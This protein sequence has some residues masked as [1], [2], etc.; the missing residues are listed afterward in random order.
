MPP[1]GSG[2]RIGRRVGVV[3]LVV[4]ASTSLIATTPVRVPALTSARSTISRSLPIAWAGAPGN[5]RAARSI[6]RQVPD[7]DLDHVVVRFRSRPAD[8]SARLA[9]AGARISR[10]ISGTSWTELATP[11]RTA[12]RARAAL[13]R[14]RAVAQ[15]V[16]SYI[17]HASTLPN[18]PQWA[19]KQSAYLSPLRLDRAWDISTGSGVTVAVVDTG[20]DLD[21]PDLSGQ[22]VAGRNVLHPGASPQDDN[23]HGTLV[24]GIVAA[25]TNNNRGGVGIAPSARVMPV[26][27]LDSTG[28]GSDA[29]IALG[30]DWAR[31]H[32]AKVINLSLGGS[33]D[34]P[35]LADAVQNAIA[36]DIV[37]VAAAGN[38]SAQTVG[39]PAADPGVIAVSA[40]TATGALTSFS[41]YGW[42]IDVA[43]PGLDITSTAL[44]SGDQYATESGTSFSSPIVAGVAALLRSRHPTWTQQQVGDQIRDTARDAG[45]PGV[46]PAFGHGIVDPLAALGGPPAAPHPAVRVGADEPNDTAID[47]TPLAIGAVHSAQIAPETDEDW[48]RVSF[49]SAGWYS[50]HVPNGPAALDH[51]MDPIVELY[52]PDNSFAASQ[53]LAGGDLLFDVTVTGNY[54]VRVRNVNG[55][56][57]PYTIVV[58]ASSEPARFAPA[59][60]VDFGTPA[61]SVGIAD[62]NGDGRKDALVAFGSNTAFPDTIVA[63][64]QTPTRSLSLLAALPT[65]PMTGGGMA[66]GDL[67]GDG[68]SDV[69]ISVNGGIDVLEHLSASTVPILIAAAGTTSVAIADVDGDSHNDIVAVGTSGVK[70]FWGPSFTAPSTS[71]NVSAGAAGSTVAVGNVTGHGDSLLDIVTSGVNVFR[72]T[73]AR[74]FAAAVLHT[75]TNGSAVAVGNV[76]ADSAPDVVTSVRASPGAVSRLVSDGSGGLVGAAALPTEAKPEPIAVSDVDGDGRDDIVVV[77][78]FVSA[79][80]FSAPADVGFLPQTAPGVFGAEETF[81]IDDFNTAYDSKAL[82]VGDLEGDGRDDVLVATDSA[83]RSWCRTPGCSLRSA[84]PGSSTRSRSRSRRTWPRA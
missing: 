81:S 42:R 43:A 71:T 49:A 28:S 13:L 32:G 47:A 59:L 26:K 44:G 60:G 53:D 29:D 8:L 14:D 10:V 84:R 58:Q 67:D 21:H 76:N 78:D 79:G 27:V 31:T 54:L 30:I 20:T 19:A 65:D 34:D 52:H 45:L 11:N 66:T 2:M 16:F 73:S 51:E 33:F 37:V 4:A 24:S 77:H 64:A 25:R 39:F 18:D 7:I 48:Y 12:R 38:D 63:F 83:S 35:V 61:Q 15:V 23:G 70:V 40:T 62:V 41:S 50:I 80:F 57:A 82:A 5:G 46:D 56:S 3:A 68:K 22:L 72:Q 6:G 9:L 1:A 36:A 55:S 74:S 69:A 17:R 75:V